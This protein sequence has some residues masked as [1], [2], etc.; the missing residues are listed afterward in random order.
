MRRV[1]GIGA[2]AL[3]ISGVGVAS[4]TPA[5]AVTDHKRIECRMVF[6]ELDLNFG[7]EFPGEVDYLGTSDD[8]GVW[9]Q[10]D[11]VIAWSRY[12]DSIGWETETCAMTQGAYRTDIVWQP[13]AEGSAQ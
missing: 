2:M 7:P 10:A 8:V 13:G 3:A 12:E 5:H 4:A 1:L 6:P 9:I 11:T